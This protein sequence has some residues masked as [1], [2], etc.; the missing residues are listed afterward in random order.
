MGFRDDVGSILALSAGLILLRLAVS[1][2]LLWP[3]YRRT[4]GFQPVHIRSISDHTMKMLFHGALLLFGLAVFPFEP[5]FSWTSLSGVWGDYFA[6]RQSAGVKWY[7]FAQCA[8]SVCALAFHFFE[9]KKKDHWMMLFHHFA[10]IFLITGSWH[11]GASRMG[12]MILF[13]RELSDVCIH[14]TKVCT[15]LGPGYGTPAL[16]FF[17]ALLVTWVPLRLVLYP[18]LIRSGVVDTLPIVMVDPSL[19]GPRWAIVLGLGTLVPLDWYWFLI[20]VQ[21][22]IRRAKHGKLV[23]SREVRKFD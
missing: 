18:L 13:S 5:W 20:A 23:D 12:C 14:A 16:I 22:A 8:A 6:Q 9:E 10:A 21:V 4:F 17:V 19:A 3:F 1:R 2:G 7:Y 15:M 11:C